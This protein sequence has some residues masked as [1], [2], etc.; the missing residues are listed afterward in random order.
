VQRQR[1]HA[2]LVVRQCRHR[3]ASR[4]VPESVL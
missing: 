2:L 1:A 4:Q 3:L